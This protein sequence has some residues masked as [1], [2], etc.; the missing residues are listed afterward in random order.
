MDYYSILGVTSSATTDEIKRA[1]RKQAMKLHPDRGGDAEEFKKLNEAYDILSDPAKRQLYDAPK[2]DYQFNSKDFDFDDIFK[3]SGMKSNQFEDL[4]RSYY[5]RYNV[6]NRDLTLSAEITLEDVMSGTQLVVDY[7]LS[8]GRQETVTVNIPAGAKH[9]DAIRYHKLGDDRIAEAARGD[10]IIKLKVRKNPN[11]ER[12][13]DNLITKA[14]VDA[15]DLITGDV[16]LVNTLDKKTVKLTI[17]QG[18]Q[19]GTVFN[20]PGYGLP[21]RR[22]GKQGNLYVMITATIPTNIDNSLIEA[23]KQRKAPTDSK[24]EKD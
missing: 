22:T 20:I 5:T 16:I 2:N 18:T 10:L 9:G 15:L 21:N 24:N 4:F 1:Y 3:S 17:P 8:S 7:T 12:D 14:A 11:W 13:G 23:I 19:H 6:K